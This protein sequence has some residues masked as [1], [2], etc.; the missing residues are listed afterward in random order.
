MI[1]IYVPTQRPTLLLSM[2]LI[3]F[4]PFNPFNSWNLDVCCVTQ[5]ECQ[6]SSDISTF[7]SVSNFTLTYRDLLSLWI[8]KPRYSFEFVFLFAPTSK[9]NTVEP[10]VFSSVQGYFH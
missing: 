8:W 7:N 10:A 5:I 4:N 9:S 1:S 2:E 3:I 6:S